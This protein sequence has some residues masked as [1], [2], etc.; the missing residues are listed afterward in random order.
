MT[1]LLGLGFCL[2]LFGWHSLILLPQYW[3][4]KMEK[5]T[6]VLKCRSERAF[7]NINKTTKKRKKSRK[8]N[9]STT[10]PCGWTPRFVPEEATS[11]YPMIGQ[12]KVSSGLSLLGNKR[13][14]PTHCV[15]E[16]KSGKKTPL[17]FRWKPEARL[18]RKPHKNTPPLIP[19]FLNLVFQQQAAL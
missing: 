5:S 11:T 19:I 3:I 10:K 4:L 17:C 15:N 8:K 14:R 6:A 1:K 2:Q 16:Y 12:T 9:P 13:G 7:Y 18:S